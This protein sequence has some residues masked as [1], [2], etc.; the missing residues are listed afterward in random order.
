MG[1]F[2]GPNI[3]RDGLICCL[4]AASP[5]SNVK[6]GNTWYDLSG[7]NFHGNLY[8]GITFEKVAGVDAVTLDGTNQWIGNTTMTGALNS[9]T[10]ELAFYHNGA[11]QNSSYGVVSI[12]SNGAYGP[13]HY[14]HTSCTGGHYFPGSPSGDY[15]GYNGGWSINAWNLQTWVYTDTRTDSGSH[16]KY[17]NGD[18]STG[19]TGYNYHNLGSGRGSNGYGLGT[20][21]GGGAVYKG[22][23]AYFRFYDRALS[24]EEVK[25][26]A[27]ATKIRLGLS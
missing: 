16:A 23:Y 5:R 21:S 10:L 14:C 25:Q 6:E 9:F 8:N 24:A 15:P 3:V 26:N 7:N 18:Y 4:D 19:R 22:S 1:Q 2:R 13:M 27:I 20:Y 17:V 12:G 11:D